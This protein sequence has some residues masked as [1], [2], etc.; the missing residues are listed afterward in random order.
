MHRRVKFDY[1]NGTCI[2]GQALTVITIYEEG[3]GKKALKKAEEDFKTSRSL[4]WKNGKYE[5]GAKGKGKKKC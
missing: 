5:F 4:V 1:K 3:L 2:D